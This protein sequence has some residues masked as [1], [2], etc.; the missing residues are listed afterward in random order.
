MPNVPRNTQIES[1]ADR[2]I[3]T[4]GSVVKAGNSLGSTGKAGNSPRVGISRSAPEADFHY[5]S[6]L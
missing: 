5:C 6:Y 4:L 3:P 1:D 2:G